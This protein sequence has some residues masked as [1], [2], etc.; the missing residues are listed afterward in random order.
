MRVIGILVGGVLRLIGGFGAFE[1][2]LMDF[3]ENEGFRTL[4]SGNHEGFF[5]VPGFENWF[6]ALG[7]GNYWGIWG[8][9]GDLGFRVSKGCRAVLD[10]PK[11][12]A[13][14]FET[15]RPLNS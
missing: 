15:P 11:S 3:A 2:L 12:E 4:F 6:R 10:S 8:L 7:F 13:R 9:K 5:V 14:S 1:S